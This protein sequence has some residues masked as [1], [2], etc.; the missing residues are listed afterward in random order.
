MDVVAP[1]FRI[2]AKM[3]PHENL[4]EVLLNR[5]D[6][7]ALV[8]VVVKFIHNF[9]NL[10]VNIYPFFTLELYLKWMLFSILIVVILI[11]L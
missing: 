8:E 7:E 4:N 2:V 6:S 11:I 1:I 3:Q 10:Y 5:L 9:P